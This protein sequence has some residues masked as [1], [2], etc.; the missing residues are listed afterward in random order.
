[1][2]QE[3]NT[4]AY[5]RGYY[6]GILSGIRT[7]CGLGPKDPIPEQF[8]I[9]VIQHHTWASSNRDDVSMLE[10][11]PPSPLPPSEPLP[12]VRK[13][14]PEELDPPKHWSEKYD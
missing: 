3:E 12:M 7:A 8:A 5:R 11:P 10:T 6:D 1:M 13:H 2:S 9:I 14:S 4:P